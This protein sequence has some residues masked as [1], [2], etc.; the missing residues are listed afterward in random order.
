MITAMFTCTLSV[1]ARKSR[2]LSS[3][4]P[5]GLSSCLPKNQFAR[6]LVVLLTIAN[7]GIITRES[8][9]KGFEIR[10]DLFI[11]MKSILLDLIKISCCIYFVTQCRQCSEECLFKKFRRRS[12]INTRRRHSPLL[13]LISSGPSRRSIPPLRSWIICVD[14][15]VMPTLGNIWDE[16]SAALLAL[17]A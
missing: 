13:W 16:N 14:L 2:G 5:K 17:G 3:W 6:F 15:M 11:A 7:Q 8:C 9:I 10:I 1:A 4:L 12:N